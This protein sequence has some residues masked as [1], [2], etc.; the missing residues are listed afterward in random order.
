MKGVD[1]IHE[2]HPSYSKQNSKSILY[3]NHDF[4]PMSTPGVWR[5]LWF[6]KYLAEYGYKITVICSNKTYWCDRYDTSLLDLIPQ[7][8]Q[9]KRIKGVFIEDI[10]KYIED[11]IKIF[12]SKFALK[13]FEGIEWRII[14]YYPNPNFLWFLKATL[15]GMFI[16]TRNKFDAIIT[17]G[18]PHICHVVG[19]LIKKISR[20]H[21]IMDYRDLWTDDPAQSPQSGYQKNLFKY[22]EEK[23]IKESDAVVVVSPSWQS[24]LMA[25]YTRQKDKSRFFM[26]R[27]GHNIRNTPC[28]EDYKII[29]SARLH[30]HNNGTPQ[31]LSK[32]TALLDAICLLRSRDISEENLPLVTYSGI[33]NFMEYA[34]Q[35]RSLEQH[36]INL[37]NMSYRQCIEYSMKSDVLL[38]IVNNENPS[39]WGTI[40]AKTYEAMALGKHILGIVP[41]R[42]DVR[43]LLN[44]YG[45]ATIC[46]VDDPE[47]ICDGLVR[48]RELHIQNKLNIL[49]DYGEIDS[50]A[51]KYSR[52]SQSQKLVDLITLMTNS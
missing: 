44:E 22:L 47:N 34:I 5:A 2:P 18:P 8:V 15:Y 21:W 11:K 51:E 27:N 41:L 48:L 49:S 43:E 1:D 39:R 12:N 28:K 4:P 13:V 24:H 38:V 20:S 42:S 23:S 33:D 16:S 52:E 29:K 31:L 37:K 9:V 19:M 30:I 36:V 32:T 35:E 45:C 6:I 25:K 7:K 3:I 40:P 10:L 50:I 17:S 46:D 14:K 26:I